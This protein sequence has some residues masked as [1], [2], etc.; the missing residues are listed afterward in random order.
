M[1]GE[2]LSHDDGIEIETGDLF[3]RA[4]TR[5]NGALQ[6]YYFRVDVCTPNGVEVMEIENGEEL[7]R[8]FVPWNDLMKRVRDGDLERVDELPFAVA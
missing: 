5:P 3:E 7:Y 8:L 1:K 2:T 4:F 6:T